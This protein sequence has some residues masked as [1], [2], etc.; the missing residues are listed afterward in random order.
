MY[1]FIYL[2]GIESVA[3]WIR[4][5]SIANGLS[6]AGRITTVDNVNLS[7]CIVECF[8]DESCVTVG[9]S[10]SGEGCQLYGLDLEDHQHMTTQMGTYFYKC[11]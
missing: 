2:S 6:L 9:V 10:E 1:L 4:E 7:Q 8:M 11:G 5:A 3:T